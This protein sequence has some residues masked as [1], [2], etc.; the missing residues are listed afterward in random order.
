MQISAETQHLI[1]KSSGRER[2]VMDLA[3][4]R[5]DVLVRKARKAGVKAKRRVV[6]GKC[7]V[8]TI[9][10]VIRDG[11]DLA[12]VGTR[13]FGT[14]KSV[15]HSTGAKLL[16]K[17]PS[18]VLITKPGSS[19]MF[20]SILAAHD[21]TEVGN[22][23]TEA[24]IYLAKQQGADLHILQSSDS[25]SAGMNQTT[26]GSPNPELTS[27][28]ERKIW[29]EDHIARARLKE[30]PS[31]HEVKGTSYSSNIMEHVERH[32]I[33]LLVVGSEVCT[34]FTWLFRRNIAQRLASEIPC[35]LL[36][37]KPRELVSSRSLDEPEFT[38][39]EQRDQL[40]A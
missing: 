26:G 22:R 23:A 33:G 25:R 37:M 9:R 11:H 13:Q 35:S 28:I 36:V 30:R 40:G 38:K 17:C 3:T 10:E 20:S 2:T 29:L 18:P 14:L 6:F 1:Q 12:V 27:R 24:A 4:D 39:A 21:F 16:A 19:T 7:W 15:L 32:K 8:E 5:L 31:I 34:G